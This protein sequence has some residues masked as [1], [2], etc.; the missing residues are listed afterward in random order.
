MSDDVIDLQAAREARERRN[1]PTPAPGFV[2]T[3]V[4][5]VEWFTFTCSCKD[6]EGTFTFDIMAKDFADAQRRIK[7]IGENGRVDGK[8]FEIIPYK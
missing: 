6:E 3:D 1:E 7:M 4:H 8:L 5:G 2:A